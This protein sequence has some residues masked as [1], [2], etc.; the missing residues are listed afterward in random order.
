[1]AEPPD[2]HQNTPPRGVPPPAPARWGPP[3]QRVVDPLPY[4]WGTPSPTGGYP[5]PYE[6]KLDRLLCEWGYL[7]AFC[8]M[9]HRMGLS[10]G[11]NPLVWRRRRLPAAVA[12]PSKIAGFGG[13][14]VISLYTCPFK[15]LGAS[16]P[17]GNPDGGL[18]GMFYWVPNNIS[19]FLIFDCAA[20]AAGQS[21]AAPHSGFAP[22]DN[23]I[24]WAM[25][26]KALRYPR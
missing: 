4:E 23:L 10:S 3:P 22:L 5:L 18:E 6:E 24:R 16:P 1:M 12:A 21:T 20:T 9:A 19:G 15:M 26:Q 25:E 17:R 11:A 2:G 14:K 7:M 8:S 13:K